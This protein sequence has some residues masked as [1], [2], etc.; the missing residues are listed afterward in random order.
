MTHTNLRLKWHVANVHIEPKPEY[1]DGEGFFKH[2]F[3]AQL[4]IDILLIETL[5][6]IRQF[7]V[8]IK[9]KADFLQNSQCLESDT[10]F[11]RCQDCDF[12]TKGQLTMA[13][14]AL[15]VHQR[16]LQE[17]LHVGSRKRAAADANKP[18]MCDLCGFT[19]A[20]QGELAEH[21]KARH[22]MKYQCDMCNFSTNGEKR[23]SN[24]AKLPHDH[25]CGHCSFRVSAVGQTTGGM[26]VLEIYEYG[27]NWCWRFH[28]PGIFPV[29]RLG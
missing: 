20:S 7:T 26:G 11:I 2:I 19:G 16:V 9:N 29:A 14:H 3:Q 15:D 23:F 22:S 12:V 13:N 10:P 4:I 21:R 6:V 17:K 1:R 8:T 5:L 28:F 25:Q 18:A 24:H 27:K